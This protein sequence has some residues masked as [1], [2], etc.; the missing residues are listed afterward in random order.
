MSRSLAAATISA[1]ATKNPRLSRRAALFL[2]AAALCCVLAGSWVILAVRNA[3]EQTQ[4]REAYLPAL[5]ARARH[6]PY[7]GPLLALTGARLMEAHEHPAAAAVLRRALA[8]GEQNEHVWLALAAAVAASGDIPRARADLELGRNAHPASSVL[9]AALEASKA[10]GAS[11]SAGDLAA[12]ISP[13]GPRPLVL[14]YARGSFL[15]GF[16]E[17]RGRRHPETSGF[18]TRERW[19]R[20]KPKD[21]RV[22]RL[23]GLALAENRR[24]VEAGPVLRRALDLAPRSP[25]VR[26]AFSDVLARTGL[27]GKAGL[28]YIECLKM[29]PNWLPALLGLGRTALAENLEF[30]VQCFERAT[31]QDPRNV[32]AWIGLGR[33]RQKLRGGE[34][35]AAA[36]A[37]RTAARLAPGRT[38][39]FADYA[40]ALRGA[41]QWDQ[42][43]AVLRRR[44][45]V[46]PGDARSHFLLAGV[47]A[48]NKATPEREAEAET[49]GRE[50]LRLA[51]HLPVAEVQL[52]RLLL[53]R[54]KVAESVA[55]LGD[56]LTHDP[57]N[58]SAMNSLAS[59]QVRNGQ[60]KLAQQLFL[61][62][63]AVFVDQQR[64]SVLENKRKENF[65]DL[66][67][68]EK[69]RP[70]YL[71]LGQTENARRAA[72][73][74]RELRA[75]PARVARGLKDYRA[76]LQAPPCPSPEDCKE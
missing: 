44:L 51:P 23:W 62:S 59:A 8:A 7:D 15:N 47:L 30:G 45:A 42:A 11:A 60:K 70:L 46:A 4:R 65:L 20:E 39:F 16:S 5:E 48:D 56:A 1:P 63:H 17:W 41:Y 73:A 33:A 27:T 55:L 43:E 19:V 24:E 22:L 54:N 9:R 12:A 14:A 18:A 71:R 13:N 40:A 75:N 2:V 37:F 58:P 3:W 50:A 36:E 29:R 57:Y 28:Q 21:A 49:H 34:D 31:Q 32:E 76:S 53:R 67:T 35:E 25:E 72:D 38:D 74:A 52:G 61:R 66:A 6:S 26:L 68:H 64:V 10:L 69:L